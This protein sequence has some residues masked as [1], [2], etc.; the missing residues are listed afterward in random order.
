MTERSD[1]KGNSGKSRGYDRSSRPKDRPGKHSASRG[2][3]VFGKRRPQGEE[4]GKD[5][6]FGEKKPKTVKTTPTGNVIKIWREGFRDNMAADESPAPKP[7][8]PEP[9][10]APS[11]GKK[12]WVKGKNHSKSGDA[13]PPGHDKHIDVTTYYVEEQEKMYAE[14]QKKRLERKRKASMPRPNRPH[15]DIPVSA[16]EVL[17][18]ADDVTIIE[19]NVERIYTIGFDGISVQKLLQKL[20]DVGVN[21][22][23]DTRIDESMLQPG[24]SKARDLAILFKEAA[25]IEYRREDI[26]IP[27]RDISA[28]YISDR[29][30]L[31]Y[32]SAYKEQLL[33]MRVDKTLNRRM[34]SMNKVAILG[35]HKKA[36]EDL[37]SISAQYLKEEWNV[38]AIINL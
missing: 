12:L 38:T 4:S 35:D 6:P 22:A 34:F 10:K 16:S 31:R 15:H 13:P 32:V 37:R 9:K 5:K 14:R 30:W 20:V 24:F 33:K 26:L 21:I 18:S 29:N 2:Q 27:R 7:A 8:A 17:P 3:K 23:I 36:E 28:T 19:P 25:G 1:N 11:S